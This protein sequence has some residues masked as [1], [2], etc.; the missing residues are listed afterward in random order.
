MILG[1]KPLSMAEAKQYVEKDSGAEIKGFIKKFIKLDSKKASELRSK[2]EKMDMMKMKEEHI[3][4][5]IDLLPETSEDLNKI[6]S[7]VGLDEDET[8]KILETIKEYK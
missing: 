1:K 7:D 8:K 3:V 4:K 5:I 2:L 6:F